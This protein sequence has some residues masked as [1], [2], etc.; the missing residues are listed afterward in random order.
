VPKIFKFTVP[1]TP[2]GKE[3][4]RVAFQGNKIHAYTPD[5]TVFAEHKIKDVVEGKGA[6]FPEHQGVRV[7][8]TFYRPMP[9][10]PT[11]NRLQ[12]ICRGY[13]V[14]F[15]PVIAPDVDNYQK[16]LQDALN[17]IVY[18]DDCQVTDV[19]I[20]KRWVEKGQ[21]PRIEFTLTEDDGT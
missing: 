3:R 5:R 6:W 13:N 20:K 15:L 1:M 2:V 11:V 21:Q 8:A 4:A 19:H 16:T 14:P 17:M 9:D 7:E 10:N 12:Q 18:P